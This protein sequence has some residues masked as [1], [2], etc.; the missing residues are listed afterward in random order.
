MLTLAL[1]LILMITVIHPKVAAKKAEVENE[2][3][4][5]AQE[6]AEMEKHVSL[7][8]THTLGLAPSSLS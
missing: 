4:A 7:P 1:A 2:A 5:A 8:L 6:K 3:K